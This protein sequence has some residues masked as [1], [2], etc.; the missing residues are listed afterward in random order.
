[1]PRTK[2]QSGQKKIDVPVCSSSSRVTP[3]TSALQYGQI[4]RVEF[5]GAS[6]QFVDFSKSEP[7]KVD[8]TSAVVGHVSFR[9]PTG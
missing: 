8:F 9:R 3:C 1:M 6:V 5:I 2:R 7:I 4:G